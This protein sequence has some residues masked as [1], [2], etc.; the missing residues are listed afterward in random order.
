MTDVIKE[1]VVPNMKKP[2]YIRGTLFAL[3]G[4]IAGA[5][6]WL[7]L[8][9]MNFIASIASYL[10]AWS[11]AWLY[12]KGA[13]RIDRKSV[14]III[15]LIVFGLALSLYASFTADSIG[16]LFDNYA[17]ARQEGTLGLLRD[18]AFWSFNNQSLVTGEVIK[19]YTNDIIFSLGFTLLGVYGTIKDTFFMT[20]TQNTK[21]N[22]TPIATEK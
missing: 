3:P 4:V 15:S 2:N 13:G 7:S 12:T 8:W 22:T 17:G 21:S 18:S 16:Y 5:A 11:I 10:M 19:S 9:R 14:Y 6:I 1:A 20:A